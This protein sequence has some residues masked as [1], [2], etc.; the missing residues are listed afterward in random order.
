MK[1]D[2][3]WIEAVVARIRDRLDSPD[4]ADDHVRLISVDWAGSRMRII[5]EYD[6]I[7]QPVGRTREISHWRETHGNDPELVGDHLAWDVREP[8]NLDKA[9]SHRGVRWTGETGTDPML[10]QGGNK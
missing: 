10:R 2:D 9:V 7:D 5:V 1:S 4:S 3:P 8:P 6:Y